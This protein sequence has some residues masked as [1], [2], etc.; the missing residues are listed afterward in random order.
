[1]M[2]MAARVAVGANAGQDSNQYESRSALATPP[3]HSHDLAN[4]DANN[5]SGRQ[6]TSMESP[7]PRVLSD[8]LWKPLMDA[9]GRA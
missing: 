7:H 1:M 9:R 5:V 2:V 6:W 4:E 3:G 8:R